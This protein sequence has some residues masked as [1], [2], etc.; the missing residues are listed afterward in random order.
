MAGKKVQMFELS[1]VCCTFEVK[2]PPSKL[3]CHTHFNV[4]MYC[5]S[6]LV[7]SKCVVNNVGM[8]QKSGGCVVVCFCLISQSSNATFV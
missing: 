6:A 7:Q 2:F 1:F 8:F 4:C 5:T 3:R